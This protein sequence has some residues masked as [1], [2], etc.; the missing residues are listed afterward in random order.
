MFNLKFYYYVEKQKVKAIGL[1]STALGLGLN[2]QYAW[3]D[4]SF[5]ESPSTNAHIL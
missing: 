2:M 4:Y 3:N 1:L 5:K